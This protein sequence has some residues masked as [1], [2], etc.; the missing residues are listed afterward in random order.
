MTRVLEVMALSTGGIGRHVASLVTA[1][2][3]D[4]VEIDIAAPASTVTPMPK[5][6]IP[7]DIPAGVSFSMMSARR[8]LA[9]MIEQGRYDL[10][11]AHGLRAGLVSLQAASDTP[12]IVTLHNLIRRET[13]GRLLSIL[14]RRGETRILDEARRVFAVSEEM[15][16]TLAQRVP[17]Q[18]HKIELLRIGLPEPKA[19]RSADEVRGELDAVDRPLVLTVA[20]LARQKALDVLLRAIAMIDEA[21]LAIVGDGP[22]EAELRSLARELAIAD[23]VRFVGRREE[24]GDYLHAADVFAL[25]STWEA[26]ALAAQEAILAEVPVVSSAVGGMPELIID[27]VSGL[28][29]PPKDPKRLAKG[30][31]ELLE[32]PDIARAYARRAKADLRSG[33]SDEAMLARVR[34]EYLET[35]HV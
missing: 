4:G 30:I 22:L 3:G 14:F 32:S 31:R 5:A 26:R 34:S 21:V 23:R 10:V 18:A 27:R 20:R 2:D 35:T 1:L 13:S 19:S 16:A 7:L 28:L 9:E 11:H 29:V 24:V 25:S 6:V 17:R 8:A 33:Y 15:A 12:V